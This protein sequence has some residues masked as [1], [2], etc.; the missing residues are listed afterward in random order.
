MEIPLSD[1]AFAD[2]EQ[3]PAVD[4]I[5][6][7]LK[8]LL[9]VDENTTYVAFNNRYL[10]KSM[11][12]YSYS[13]NISKQLLSKA[14]EITLTRDHLKLKKKL[15]N[16]EAKFIVWVEC[17]S[18]VTPKTTN[19]LKKEEAQVLK[20]KER[21]SASSSRTFD[22]PATAN[23]PFTSY[24][25]PTVSRASSLDLNLTVSDFFASLIRSSDND[26]TRTKFGE[27]KDFL[28]ADGYGIVEDL[29]GVDDWSKY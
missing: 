13:T 15:L 26:A 23:Q 12:S 7:F 1:L 18:P 6:D 28:T 19:Q 4:T 17:N 16:Y 20:Q 14:T 3:D 24:P 27:Y 5:P 29:L 11:K 22:G 25:L 8:Y 2:E 10:P 9:E 21:D